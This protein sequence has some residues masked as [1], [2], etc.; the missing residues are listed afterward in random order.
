MRTR[1]AR[2]TAEEVPSA[3]GFFRQLFRGMKYE[4]SRSTDAIV[5]SARQAEGRLFVPCSLSQ[6][7]NVK[8]V[9]E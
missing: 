6:L 9:R 1:F 7:G 5:Q 8:R 3:V 2:P 4:Q